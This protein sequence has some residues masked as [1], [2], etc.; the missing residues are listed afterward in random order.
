MLGLP[1]HSFKNVFK[2]H[3]RAFTGSSF[4]KLGNPVLEISKSQKERFTP[5]TLLML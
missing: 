3:G 2:E 1:L 4:L 5:R